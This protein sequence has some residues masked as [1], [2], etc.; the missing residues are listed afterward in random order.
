MTNDGLSQA[1]EARQARGRRIAATSKVRMTRDELWLVPSESNGGTYL[2]DMIEQTCTCPDHMDNHFMC[3]HIHAVTYT[4]L[5]T[6]DENG[7]V[8]TT[9]KLKISYSQNWSAYNKAQCTEKAHVQQ[10]LRGLCDGIVQPP[11]VRGRPSLP[12]SD[13]IYGSVMKVYTTFSGRRAT[14]DVKD[15]EAKGLIEHAPHYNSIF[16]YLGRAELTP[17]FKALIEESALPLKAI[18]SQ[19]AVD[20]TGFGT[21]TYSRWYDY[22]FGREMRYMN[23]L[24]AHAMVG[25]RT[26]VVT[27]IEVT[28]GDKHDSPQFAGLV[29]STAKRFNV[30][31]VSADKAYLS[32]D[33]LDAV[34]AVGGVP[35][36]PF[37]SNNKAE[38]P[39]QWQKLW[40]CFWYRRG[41][42]DH[43][44]H[45]RS[46][47]ETTFSMIKRKFGGS[48]RSKKHDSQVNEVLA[49]VLC[50]NLA[51]LVHE[52]HELGIAP[53]FW[54]S[55][56]SPLG[57]A[58]HPGLR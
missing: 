36:I 29:A 24:K 15:C 55:V 14:T 57:L 10:L 48:V 9:E 38:G 13:V 16:N 45:Q 56:S 12:L 32:H 40:H 20:A 27:S 26:N 33:N 11:H 34:A 3:K 53:E 51:V 18:E 22:K 35:Y 42:F 44:Y 39:E 58:A 17:L 21:S 31:E 23:W 54:G 25:V 37:K 19:F 4:R 52:V 43:H 7:T 50:H 1:L 46:N 28:E 30:K 8:V 41:E 2:V 5:R 6:I 47:S 49:K